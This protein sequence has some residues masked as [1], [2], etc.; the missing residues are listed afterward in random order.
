[1]SKPTIPE[2]FPV[3]EKYYKDRLYEG[4]RY[5]FHKLIITEVN[6]TN[7][8]INYFI[9]DCKK[10]GDEEG[11]KVGKLLLQLSKTQR[12]KICSLLPF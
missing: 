4:N 7:G 1:M 3:I 8:D 12:S 11:L 10:D 6:I 5:S 2:V 9:E